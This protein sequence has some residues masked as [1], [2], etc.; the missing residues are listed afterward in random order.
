MLW[1]IAIVLFILWA[2]G[3]IGFHVLGTYIHILLIF[4]IIAILVQVIQGRRGAL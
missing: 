2:L 1:T 4:A 3:F